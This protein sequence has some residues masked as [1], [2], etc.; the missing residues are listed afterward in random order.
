M[1]ALSCG[2]ECDRYSAALRPS[3][4]HIPMDQN[5]SIDPALGVISAQ[6]RWEPTLLAGLA[7]RR[8]RW[9]VRRFDRAAENFSPMPT[10]KYSALPSRDQCEGHQPL[11]IKVGARP[12]TGASHAPALPPLIGKSTVTQLPSGATAWNSTIGFSNTRTYR[13][14]VRI[15]S[16]QIVGTSTEASEEHLPRVVECGLIAAADQ[17]LRRAHADRA[18]RSRSAIAPSRPSRKNH[19]PAHRMRR[20]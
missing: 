7:G 17:H 10:S 14:A 20:S 1:I 15:H 3:R 9:A 18:E 2:A 16:M 8:H 5:P 19:L 11:R 4:T 12:S 13:A 6:R